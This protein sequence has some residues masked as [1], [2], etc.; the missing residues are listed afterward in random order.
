MASLVATSST[1][2]QRGLGPSERPAISSTINAV[3]D[4]GLRL[5]TY[6]EAADWD[7]LED[8]LPSSHLWINGRPR[9]TAAVLQQA[10]EL[11]CDAVDVDLTLVRVLAAEQGKDRAHYSFTCC[12]V[13][14]V[15]GSWDER[16]HSFDLHIGL[17]QKERREWVITYFGIAPPTP[18]ILPFP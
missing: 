15:R 7:A 17:E 13:W 12:L 11:L 8:L 2:A 18:E 9:P 4:V 6:L 10:E 3:R 1:S 16:E 14:G 5:K